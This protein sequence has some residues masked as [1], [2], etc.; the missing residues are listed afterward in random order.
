MTELDSFGYNYPL[1]AVVAG[2]YLGGNG[3]KEAMYPI[4]YTDSEGQAL[5]GSKRYTLKFD[6][7][8]PVNAFWSLRGPS[9]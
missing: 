8:P 6:T 1:S 4:R 7:L 9:M 2:T 5:S 3:D